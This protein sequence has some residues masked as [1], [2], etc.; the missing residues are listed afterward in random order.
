[1]ALY[2]E[3]KQDDGVVTKYHRILFVQT[4]VNR[5]NSIAVLSYVDEDSRE[6]EKSAIVYQPYIKSITYE[7]T[8]NEAMTVESAYEYLKSMP[9]FEGAVDV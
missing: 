5:Q 7:T 9:Q 4:T 2:K 1:M 8:Y 3:I 6:N